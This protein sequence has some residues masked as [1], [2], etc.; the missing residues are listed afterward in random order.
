MY[1]LIDDEIQELKERLFQLQLE[2][3]DMDE[4]IKRLYEESFVDQ[5][6]VSR[7]KRRKLQIKDAIT[8][9]ESRL[10]PDLNA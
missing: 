7:L 8:R 3:R 9:L 6:Q 5:L 2:H 1:S 4:L 10:I